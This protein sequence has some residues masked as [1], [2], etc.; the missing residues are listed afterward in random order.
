MREPTEI[1]NRQYQRLQNLFA[2]AR[3]R[4]LDAGGN[5][6][7]SGGSLNKQ[8]YLTEAEKQE[9]RELGQQVFSRSNSSVKT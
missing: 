6:N 5:P 8:D 3:Q 2:I 9:I 1:E 4:Y 7:L